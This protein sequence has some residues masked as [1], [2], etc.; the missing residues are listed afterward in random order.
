MDD[1]NLNTNLNKKTNTNYDQTVSNLITFYNGLV[2]DFIREAY[3][4]HNPMLINIAKNFD[5]VGVGTS[6]V[7]TGG[8][9]GIEVRRVG[10][11]PQNNNQ[12]IKREQNVEFSKI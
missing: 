4:S 3:R 10:F 2:K 11:S 12:Q 6:S 5:T 9:K 7:I 1:E 8:I